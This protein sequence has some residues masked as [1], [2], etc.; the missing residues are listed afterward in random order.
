MFPAL[1]NA[2]TTTNEFTVN[3]A[4]DSM[5][6]VEIALYNPLIPTG[7]PVAARMFLPCRT[8]RMT[9]VRVR[10][11]LSETEI[12]MYGTPKRGGIGL[13]S[14]YVPNWKYSITM[15]IPTLMVLVQSITTNFGGIGCAPKEARYMRQGR[16][17]THR[18]VE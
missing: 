18:F 16:A 15:P 2:A 3:R 7:D 17:I 14:R 5:S 13:C 1:T 10:R 11:T 6:M 8:S 4:Q 9:I 12:E